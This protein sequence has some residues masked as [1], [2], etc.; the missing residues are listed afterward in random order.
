MISYIEFPIIVKWTIPVQIQGVIHIGAHWQSEFRFIIGD[1][2]Q[3]NS[4]RLYSNYKDF[5]LK[6]GWP[7]SR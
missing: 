7:F 4:R 2:H 6:V 5:V 1:G 3:T